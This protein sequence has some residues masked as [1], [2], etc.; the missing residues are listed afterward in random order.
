MV[1]Q[2]LK[3]GLGFFSWALVNHSSL[4]DHKD[5]VHELVYS[6]ASLVE[7]DE[8]GSVG[9]IGHETEGFSKV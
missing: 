9:Y 3:V 6:F 2:L 5:F 8:R 1:S 4:V 7:R